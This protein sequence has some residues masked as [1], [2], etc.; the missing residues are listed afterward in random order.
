[1]KLKRW[2]GSRLLEREQKTRANQGSEENKKHLMRLGHGEIQGKTCD[3]IQTFQETWTELFP[4]PLDFAVGLV[5]YFLSLPLN[6]PY[7]HYQVRDPPPMP[8]LPTNVEVLPWAS[9]PWHSRTSLRPQK[10]HDAFS[11]AW[12]ELKCWEDPCTQQ[13]RRD[14]P[15]NTWLVSWLACLFV[16]TL[17]LVVKCQE[18]GF[19][20]QIDWV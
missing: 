6:I 9:L 11:M 16:C 20:S 12:P 15:G 19:G 7:S 13:E 8:P 5:S 2:S 1:M 10:S 14:S 3:F 18:V 17:A 4:L